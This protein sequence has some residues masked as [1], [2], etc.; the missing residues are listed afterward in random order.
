MVRVFEVL[1]VESSLLVIH[2]RESEPCDADS[3]QLV[4]QSFDRYHLWTRTQ[5]PE[6]SW[7]NYQLVAW[8]N[9]PIRAERPNFMHTLN[10]ALTIAFLW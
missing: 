8:T 4:L 2:S 1:R 7:I 3:V 5:P 9:S 10:R 6:L